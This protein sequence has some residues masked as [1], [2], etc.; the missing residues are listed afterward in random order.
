[1]KVPL[2]WLREYVDIETPVE[3]LAQT[4]TF[5]GLEV[6]AMEYIGLPLPAHLDQMNAKV[7]G[8][9]WNR[10][11][12]VVGEITEVNPHPNADRLVLVQLND[13]EQV[14]TVLT[15][16]PNL[17]EYK[18][19]GP[20]AARLKVAYAKEG[21]H[22]YDGHQPGQKLTKLK[23]A[24]IRGVE[25]Y[26]M[27]CSEKELGI[28][29][30][31]AGIILFDEDAP[32]AGT[33]LADYIG[34]VVLD[35]AITP[36]MARNASILG[37]AREVAAL[38]GASLRQPSYA[39]RMDGPDVTSSIQ[40]DIRE[41]ELNPRFTA[42]LLEGVSIG[43]SP[44]WMQ[45][46][47]RLAGMRPI[48][49]IVDV[50]NY[51]M[52]ELGQPLHAFDYDV[53]AERAK[54]SGADVPT[55]ITRLPETGERLTTLDDVDRALDDFTILVTDTAGA[56]SLGGIMG[57]EES[58]VSDSTTNVLL[59][60]AAWNYINIRRS[61]QAQGLQTSEAG[62][63]FSRG[64]HPAMAAR[65][66]LRAIEMMRTLAG[67]AIRNGMVDE[68]PAPPAPVVVDLPLAE[69]QRLLGIELETARIV[70]ILTA[71]EFDVVNHGGSLQ[72]TVPD[73]RLDIGTGVV[74]RADLV[75][76]IA[77]IYGYE[78]IPE[79]QITDTTPPQRGNPSLEL[80]E[81]VRD[82]LANLGMQEVITYRLTVP[83]REA[84]VRAPGAPPDERPYVTLVNPIASDRAN[85]RHSLLASVLEVGEHNARF[86]ARQAVFEIGPVFLPP[87][88]NSLPAEPRRL[89]L[90]MTGPREVKN[91]AVDETRQMDFYDLKGVVD[92]L[93]A[94]LHLPAARVEPAQ[95][96]SFHPARTAR[97]CIGDEEI[98]VFGELH[99]LVREAY[100]LPE[101]PVLAAEFDAEALLAAIPYR[102][103][104]GSVS[105][106]PAVV[107]DIALI[108][109]E[110]VPAATVL[111]LI[112]Q[113]GG[114]QLVD[115]QLF[116]VYRGAQVG[117]GKKSLAYRL[118]YQSEEKTLTD[119]DAARLRNKIVKRLARELGAVLRDG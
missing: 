87:D 74:G 92:A 53:L 8:L 45:L 12:I 108:V 67:G 98:G 54:Q 44:Y 37:V 76:E 65:G 35:I 66:N 47:L 91:W 105:R 73:H 32:A 72:V 21:A 64:V 62:Y 99:P 26:S 56:L 46:R 114:R 52:L 117:A 20:L 112:A 23:R 22:I 82:L 34:D 96:P 29:D 7:S 109:D 88:E 79:T 36:N 30:E 42:T 28:S 58:E 97:L 59:E 116:D 17:F 83:E 103:P 40:I 118:T 25:S 31:H 75:E 115:V 93:V 86:H 9:E 16:A 2:S 19:K 33:P 51:A 104:T 71:L 3:E 89:A 84:R 101:Q 39:V 4:M 119:K 14:H 106:F 90:L 50:T 38:T 60:A 102:Y 61:V 10:Q 11:K 100:N 49:N 57:G 77:R 70:D 81:R 5:A 111:A 107:E 68:Y 1:M 13:G 80:E 63:R 18:G 48:N 95:H 41:P 15:G 110:A 43:P 69:V 24:K 6:E 85:M 113:T 94:G 27:A 78:R 55:L